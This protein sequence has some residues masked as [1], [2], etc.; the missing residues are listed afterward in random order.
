VADV[1][2]GMMVDI[3]ALRTRVS[4]L[5]EEKRSLDQH[6]NLKHRERNDTLVRQ[7]FSTCVLLKSRL[8]KYHVNMEHDVRQLVSSVRKEGVDRII[9]LKNK[10]SSANDNETLI[11]TLHE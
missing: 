7:L 10:L 8:D 6:L 9:K 3:T 5:E 2:R 1:C 11:H 4:Q